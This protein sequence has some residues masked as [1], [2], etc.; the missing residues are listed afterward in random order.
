MMENAC[1]RTADD[2]IDGGRSR[3][4]EGPS[5]VVTVVY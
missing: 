1:F 2:L 4:R 5:D 3:G